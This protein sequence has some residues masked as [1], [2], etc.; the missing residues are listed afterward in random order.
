[1]VLR[2]TIEMESAHPASASRISPSQSCRVSPNTAMAPPQPQ[3]AIRTA[4]PWR[5]MRLSQPE[6]TLPSRAPSAGAAT[7]S[8]VVFASPPN[9]TTATT[10]KSARGWAS[11]MALRSLKKVIRRLGR[12][13]RKRRPSITDA[14][15]V[16]FSP[17]FRPGSIEGSR[18]I[19]YSEAVKV[20]ASTVYA[21][22]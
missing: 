20:T 14:R 10:G 1:M 7:S 21:A 18:H 9:H 15:P 4:S 12:V 16:L 19:A 17:S 8:P 5:R 2:K 3:T 22:R 11:T 13:P 6:N